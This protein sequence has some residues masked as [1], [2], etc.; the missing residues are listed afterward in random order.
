MS[1]IIY[2][3]HVILVEICAIMHIIHKLWFTMLQSRSTHKRFLSINS[4]KIFAHV[5]A[6]QKLINYFKYF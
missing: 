5:P 6:N 4:E 2:I 1:L 3:V